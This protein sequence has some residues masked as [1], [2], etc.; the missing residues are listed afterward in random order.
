M[1]VIYR[2][3]RRISRTTPAGNS[4]RCD[5]LF[6]VHWCRFC[7]WFLILLSTVTLLGTF[8]IVVSR[9]CNCHFDGFFFLFSV[10]L[11]HQ[12]LKQMYRPYGSNHVLSFPNDRTPICL[13]QNQRPSR[14]C[15]GALVLR[16]DK[17]GSLNHPPPLPAETIRGAHSCLGVECL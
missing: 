6:P 8:C 5:P 16:T 15:L 9:F 17:F 13:P 3:S 7:F 12:T 2:W 14:F 10:S 4:W 1:W 11:Q